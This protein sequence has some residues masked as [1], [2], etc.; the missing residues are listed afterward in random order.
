MRRKLHLAL[1]ALLLGA[2]ACS[3]QLPDS[4]LSPDLEGH[5]Y[6]ASG[7]TVP[8][9]AAE[10]PGTFADMDDEKLW[11]FVAYSGNVAVVGLRKPGVNRGVYRGR[12]L[13]N[14]EEWR[15]A[16]HAVTSQPGVTLIFADSLLPTVK[17]RL[18]GI[19]ALRAVRRLPVVSYVEPVRAPGAGGFEP[20]SCGSSGGSSGSSSSGPD[21]WAGT[22][23]T[24]YLPSGD[25]YSDRHVGTGIDKAWARGA[26][27]QGTNIGLIDT[28]TA[29]LYEF[30]A[31]WTSGE[32]AGRW[33]QHAHAMMG[34]LAGPPGDTPCG[35]G[36]LMAG[37]IGAARD[38]RNVVGIAY[39]ANMLTV[40][41]GG[42]DVWGVGADH[43]QHAVRTA[44]SN[45]RYKSGGKVLSLAFQSQNWWWQVSDEISYWYSTI[46]DLIYIGA[47]GT[48]V[49]WV[50]VIFPADHADVL[51]ATCAEYPSGQLSNRCTGGD[52][53]DFM[54]Y[55]WMPSFQYNNTGISRIGGSSNATATLV[56]ITSQIWSRYPSSSRAQVIHRL[57]QAGDRW[58]V[59]H[60]TVGWGIVNAHRAVGGM[61]HLYLEAPYS[62]A[63][64]TSFKVLA[65]HDGE[66]PTFTYAWNNGRTSSVYVPV[67]TSQAQP[68]TERAF[69]ETYTVGAEGTS[70]LVSVTVTDP[71]DGTQKTVS[72]WVAAQT[73][74][75]YECVDPMQPCCDPTDPM[76]Y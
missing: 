46:P 60:G 65:K 30:Y 11:D 62:V 9:Y 49:N 36:T 24:Y 43:A 10:R 56:G 26:A 1:P 25:L 70:I 14:G 68:L 64:Y 41:H 72:K 45:L 42:A 74:Q 5:F 15:N 18:D 44:A 71:T 28:G 39:K 6:T 34:L 27:G 75:P 2:A 20:S 16:A 19:E 29:D 61:T 58:P 12:I 32:S 4:P 3:D 73:P 37:A 76:C 40:Q 7:Q 50:G 59:E 21:L 57:K 51:A 67:N 63:P 38:G 69:E 22:G 55:Q 52:L 13:M 54:A 31:P 35:H 33:L 17:V 47:A 53:V 23:T 48:D 8:T 66:G